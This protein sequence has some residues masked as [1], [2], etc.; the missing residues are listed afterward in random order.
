MYVTF[1]VQGAASASTEEGRFAALRTKVTELSDMSLD[2][3]AVALRAR[4]HAAWESAQTTAR[5]L[6]GK[7]V[8][9]AAVA[10]APED[11]AAAHREESTGAWSFVGLF[12]SLRGSQGGDSDGASGAQQEW[13]EGEV[14]AE[15][16]RVGVVTL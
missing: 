3:L 16:I 1:W 8:P 9:A 12:S 10:A 15:L 4:A 2:E 7:P 14:H 11:A 6:V 5:Y 13:N